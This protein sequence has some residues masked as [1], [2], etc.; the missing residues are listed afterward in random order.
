MLIVSY[1]ND[2]MLLQIT[3]HSTSYSAGCY[4]EQ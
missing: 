1:G 2:I 4:V 3:D